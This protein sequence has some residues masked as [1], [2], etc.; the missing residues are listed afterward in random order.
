VLALSPRSDQ[1]ETH[2]AIASGAAA[3]IVD[4]ANATIG[5][6][7][8]LVT[9]QRGLDPRAFCMVAFG[10][11][12]PAHANALAAALGI[13]VVLIP[14]GPGVAAALGMLVSDLRHDY[15]A[16]T[17][18]RW[19]HRTRRAWRRSSRT[20]PHRLTQHWP[21]GCSGGAHPTRALPQ[22]A[23]HRPILEA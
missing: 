8:R 20:S 6:A 9:V 4:I 2:A 14:P 17:C 22:H 7:M 16:R 10:G 23:V 5:Q 18:S 1:G 15:R 21:G 13:P 12:R 11:A 19:P 3:C